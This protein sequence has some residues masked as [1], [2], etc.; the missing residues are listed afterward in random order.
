M[1]IWYYLYLGIQQWCLDSD[2]NS[3]LH[4]EDEIDSLQCS[5]NAAPKM[6][7]SGCLSKLIS[8]E[9]KFIQVHSI[10]R[11]LCLIVVL[12]LKYIVI[13]IT[14]KNMWMSG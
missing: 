10:E 7:V 2:A 11:P 1:A 3:S 12:Q 8:A 14:V 13:W 4:K 9:V 5:L 6:K